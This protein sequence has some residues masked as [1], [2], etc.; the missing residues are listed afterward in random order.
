[1]IEQI[2]QTLDSQG[3]RVEPGSY[4]TGR[5]DQT[6]LALL[7]RQGEPAVAKVYASSA[8]ESTYRNML[9]LCARRSGT[10]TPPGLPRPIEFLSGMQVLIME[11]L[12]GRPLAELGAVDEEILDDGIRLV[13]S[14][15]GCDAQPARQRDS[16]RILRSV[17]RKARSIS[18]LAPEFS[19]PIWAVVRALEDSPAEDRELVPTTVTLA[20]NILVAP[21]RLADRRTVFSV[22]P[23]AT[24][25]TSVRGLVRGAGRGT[26]ARLVCAERAVALYGRCALKQ[27]SNPA[28][29]LPQQGWCA[30][31]QPGEIVASR[32]PS[33][34][35][36]R[37]RP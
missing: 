1:M 37:R 29:V 32:R 7:T 3:Y 19:D 23:P 27:R 15:H 9:E 2:L 5:P 14:L 20:R 28:W 34:A 4:A 25:Y 33:R 12:A 30:S 11:R 8:G 31:P 6:T 36:A 16:Q 24:S 21:G 22:T 26:D 13:A 17:R 18:E 10:A 35:S